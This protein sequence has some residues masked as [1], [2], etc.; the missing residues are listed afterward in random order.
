MSIKKNIISNFISQFYI[1]FIGVLF[2]PLYLKYLG[3]EAYGLVGF[4]VILQTWFNLLDMGLTSTVIRES[5]RYLGGAV[6][7]DAFLRLFRS[8]E[9]LFS[10]V[11]ATG[12]LV[13]FLLSGAIADSWLNVQELDPEAV[14]YAIK[15]MAVIVATRW[16][17]GLYRGL[18]SG[19]EH[20]VWLSGFN[21]A[22]SSMRFVGVLPVLAFLDATPKAYFTY[23]FL[24]AFIELAVLL[25][26]SGS[27]VP[28][29]PSGRYPGFSVASLR[30]VIRFSLSVSFLSAAWTLVTQSDKMIL[31]KLVSLSDYG[32]FS[33]V[34]L[35][36][37]GI[38]LINTPISMAMLPRLS[39]LDADGSYAKMT[40]LYRNATRLVAVLAFPAAF[41]ALFFQQRILYVWT[42]NED[43]SNL[44]GD[45]FVLY[46]LGNAVLAV[47]AFPYYLQFAKGDFKMQFIGAALNIFARVP[48]IAVAAYHW[49]MSG[50][51]W[52]WLLVNLAFLL[53]WTPFVHRRLKMERHFEWMIC[54]IGKPFIISAIIAFALNA[55]FPVYSSR[56]VLI[57]MLSVAGLVAVAFTAYLNN[58]HRF[59]K[60]FQ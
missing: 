27:L 22:F 33:L 14:E 28:K 24:I 54:D 20:Q 59:W 11:A 53:F 50:A 49:G 13:I 3:A 38:L 17:S 30:S 32:Y 39:R 56:P 48:I 36:A 45:V 9:M 23:Q 55:I 5:A 15:L 19:F 47:S 46:A 12:M 34:I 57:L 44:M 8:L 52:A 10:V 25:L 43:L 6:S 21:A 16:V 7:V 31:S 37:S 40:E 4:F 42:G 51:G 2:L 60:N 58:I 26:K 1:A 35:A 18:I 41:M 29:S